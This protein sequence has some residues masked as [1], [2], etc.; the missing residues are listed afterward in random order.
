MTYADDFR[1]QTTYTVGTKH[2]S[3]FL[4]DVFRLDFNTFSIRGPSTST[5]TVGL[6]KF[7]VDVGVGVPYTTNT[8]CL[9]DTFMVTSPGNPV[10]PTIC[11]KNTGEHS[12]LTL[13]APGFFYL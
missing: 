2:N 7:G 12:K 5:V 3:A 9:T 10:P 8:Q 11:G 1:I 13:W 6:H 4:I